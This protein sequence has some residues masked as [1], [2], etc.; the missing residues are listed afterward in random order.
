MADNNLAT[1]ATG[2]EVPAGYDIKHGIPGGAPNAGV[3]Y[4]CNVDCDRLA[5][6]GG[7][8]DAYS[9]SVKLGSGTGATSAKPTPEPATYAPKVP[10]MGQPRFPDANLPVQQ[11]RGAW[12]GLK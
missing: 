3:D 7:S 9:A 11:P 10:Q 4:E 1:R 6:G 8:P 2:S 5:T 12:K